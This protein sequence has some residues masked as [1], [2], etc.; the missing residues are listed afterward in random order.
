MTV[1]LRV[2]LIL[3]HVMCMFACQKQA[4]DVAVVAKEKAVVAKDKAA[5]VAS[6][7]KETAQVAAT[8]VQEAAAVAK[9]KAI[10]AKDKA[11]AAK[12]TV[13]EK[14]SEAYDV[15]QARATEVMQ[16]LR[17]ALAWIVNLP[18]LTMQE[19]QKLAEENE[20]EESPSAF[21]GDV[22]AEGSPVPLE[23]QRTTRRKVMSALASGLLMVIDN[24][25]TAVLAIADAVQHPIESECDPLCARVEALG[26]TDVV[27]V[28]SQGSRG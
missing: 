19:L 18:P 10:V 21:E 17:Q 26:F 5:E 16:Q 28:D 25:K 1:L 12:D 9:D 14:S 11:I 7:A 4:K 27:A 2:I 20:A 13:Q 3:Y 24:T 8:K 23:G 6:S 22:A 15:A